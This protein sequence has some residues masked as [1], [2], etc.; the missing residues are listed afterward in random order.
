MSKSILDIQETE[1]CIL[2]EILSSDLQ[3]PK[4]MPVLEAIRLLEGKA[5]IVYTSSWSGKKD[6][7]QIHID[8]PV[9]VNSR[10]YRKAMTRTTEIKKNKKIIFQGI[11]YTNRQI[12][13]DMLN[14]LERLIKRYPEYWKAA[15]SLF[16]KTGADPLTFDEIFN[17][18]ALLET[19]LINDKLLDT[20]S[21]YSCGTPR[22][23]EIASLAHVSDWSLLTKK[24]AEVAA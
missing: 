10:E 12:H 11:V 3:L 9:V 1:A 7:V 6:L 22:L 21:V 8:R 2:K 17:F 18:L 20:Y 19:L 4:T 14:R 16:G 23:R 5:K 15:L 13:L 24:D